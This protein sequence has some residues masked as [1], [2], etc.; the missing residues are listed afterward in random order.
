MLNIQISVTIKKGYCMAYNKNQIS[1]VLLCSNYQRKHSH[2]STY[3]SA[4][5]QTTCAGNRKCG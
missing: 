4:R 2:S 5:Q 3:V 1:L